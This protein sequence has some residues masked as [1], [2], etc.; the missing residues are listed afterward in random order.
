MDWIMG[1]Y[2]ILHYFLNKTDLN[3]FQEDQILIS[4]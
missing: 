3:K 2:F 1:D 4:C